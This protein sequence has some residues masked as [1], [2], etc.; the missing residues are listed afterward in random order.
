MSE[1]RTLSDR[2]KKRHINLASDEISICGS[3]I[4]HWHRE[5]REIA[6]QCVCAEKQTWL[7]NTTNKFQQNCKMKEIHSR[8]GD[9]DEAN[10]N[11]TNFDKFCSSLAPP[12]CLVYHEIVCSLCANHCNL[13][14]VHLLL[15]SMHV[16]T[17]S[18]SSR[19]S[20]KSF[21]KTFTWQRLSFVHF[22]TLSLWL[23]L[24]FSFYRSFL[25][26]ICVVCSYENS[27][28]RNSNN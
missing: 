20:N 6:T 3:A 2:N 4:A 5:G 1:S 27:N 12:R 14:H 8:L 25:C 24:F 19:C 22:F 16:D 26:H 10:P 18:I 23:S 28:F 9:G 13:S 17:C 7:T 15:Y 11:D 21:H